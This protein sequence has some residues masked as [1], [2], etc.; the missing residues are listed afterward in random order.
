MSLTTMT[1]GEIRTLAR[2]LA[3]DASAVNP[4]IPDADVNKKIDEW[5]ELVWNRQ[6]P[7]ISQVTY[8]GTDSDTGLVLTSAGDYVM[9]TAGTACST[10]RSR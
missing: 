8:D 7:R 10:S 4:L 5:Y 9:T 2:V 1:R 6:Q 3:G